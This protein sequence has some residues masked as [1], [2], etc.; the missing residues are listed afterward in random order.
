M[1]KKFLQEAGIVEKD[2]PAD[3]KEESSSAKKSSDVLFPTTT[4]STNKNPV[5]PNTGTSSVVPTL[6][7]VPKENFV[8]FFEDAM[9]Q[10][11]L[12]G[13]DY[14]EFRQ[15]L[16][17]FKERMGN[18]TTDDAILEMVLIDFEGKNITPN[19]LIGHANHYLNA[20]TKKKEQF[21]AEAE[22][23]KANIRK[24]RENQVNQL[25]ND[26]AAKQQKILNLQKE[27]ENTQHDIAQQQNSLEI[28]KSSIGEATEKL[29]I[30]QQELELAYSFMSSII[31]G[32]ISTLTSKVR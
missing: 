20:L 17:K 15:K 8:K 31:Q 28:T 19:D 13:E 27:I 12:P 6:G 26:I 7:R 24:Q 10:A 16:A 21:I 22:Q 23:E 2:S 30:S 14:Y 25:Q 4:F 3:K 18:K 29:D 5:T 32:E 11:N 1:F 9:K